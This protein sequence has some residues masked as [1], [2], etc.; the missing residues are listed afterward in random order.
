MTALQTELRPKAVKPP[1]P[2]TPSATLAIAFEGHA[3]WLHTPDADRAREVGVVVCSPLGRDA[4]CAHLPLRLLAEDLASA[5]V[6]TLRRP[7]R[8]G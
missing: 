7:S 5:G 1:Q 6:V 8:H 2:A 3:G 4:R